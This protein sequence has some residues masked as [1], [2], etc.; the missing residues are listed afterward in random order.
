[1]RGYLSDAAQYSHDLAEDGGILNGDVLAGSGPGNGRVYGVVRNQPDLAVHPLGCPSPTSSLGS[2]QVSPM[3][4]A[5]VSPTPHAPSQRSINRS[6]SSPGMGSEPSS[7]LPLL[8]YQVSA[9][10]TIIINPRVAIWVAVHRRPGRFSRVRASWLTCGANG[11]EP[12]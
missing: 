12:R 8:S 10:H 1:M 2:S 7:W 6:C 11:R 5:H 4:N 3:G 9:L